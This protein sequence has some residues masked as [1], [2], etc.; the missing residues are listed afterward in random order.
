MNH[1]HMDTQQFYDTSYEIYGI[2]AQRRYPNEEFCRFIGSRWLNSLTYEER[3]RIRLLEVGAGSG[4]NLWMA[5]REGFDAYGLELSSNGVDLCRAV[6]AEWRTQAQ[7]DQG[8]MTAMP[9]EDNF[10]DVVCDIFSS[11]CLPCAEFSI[12]LREAWRVLKP[13]GALFLYTPSTNSDAFINHAPAVKL[14]PYTLDGIRR[15]NSPYAGNT[16]PFRFLDPDAA[17]ALLESE[18][19]SV[20]SLELVGRTYRNRKE[21]F[22][23][24]VCSAI[25]NSA[26]APD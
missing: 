22:E 1:T 26:H 10:F 19:F 16:Y 25:K 23:F 4:A 18:G 8:D 14:D 20:S 12:F 5:A 3:G 17:P 21:Y 7:V 24:V 9:Y 13:G 2:K 11:Y 15:T 6:L